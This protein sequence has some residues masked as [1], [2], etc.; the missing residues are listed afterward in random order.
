[1]RYAAESAHNLTGQKESAEYQEQASTPPMKATRSRC[2]D[3]RA[4]AMAGFEISWWMPPQCLPGKPV[5]GDISSRLP[6]Q[7][8]AGECVFLECI[9]AANLFLAICR[10][11]RTQ[12]A[13][14]A[15][16]GYMSVIRRLS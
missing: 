16:A 11:S 10:A 6:A 15:L 14:G 13:A 2:S 8:A 12:P 7:I 5:A 3:Q 9:A 4:N 1:M